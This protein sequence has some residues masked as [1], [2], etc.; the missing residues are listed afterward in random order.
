MA[1]SGP[2]LTES[3]WKRIAPLLPNR[4]RIAVV[5]ARGHGFVSTTGLFAIPVS[6]TNLSR[7]AS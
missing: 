5:A 2:L 6:P 7:A 1:R 4:E 3:Q